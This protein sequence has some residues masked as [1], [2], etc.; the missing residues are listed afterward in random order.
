MPDAP[1]DLRL[2]PRPAVYLGLGVPH[3]GGPVHLQ[4]PVRLVN[5]AAGPVRVRSA[6][7][8]GEPL[9]TAA[10]TDV[11]VVQ[12]SSAQVLL[13]QDVSCPKGRAPTTPETGG[14]LLVDVLD[15]DGARRRLQLLLPPEPFASVTQELRQ[16]CGYV[17]AQEAVQVRAGP[18]RLAGGTLIVPLVLTNSSAEPARL[19]AVLPAVPILQVQAVIGLPLPLPLPLPVALGTRP[20]PPGSALPSTAVSLRVR[21]GPRGCAAVPDAVGLLALLRVDHGPGT[22]V[23]TLYPADTGRALPLLLARCRR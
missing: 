16:L 5:A 1:L 17:P 11:R 3:P 22:A 2:E 8:R 21:L 23:G 4:V 19:L 10:R 20:R 12:G 15:V 18:G 13:E 9:R 14:A 7:V 6:Q